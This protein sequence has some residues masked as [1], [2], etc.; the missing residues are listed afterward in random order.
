MKGSVRSPRF[1]K[2]GISYNTVPCVSFLPWKNSE[3][4]VASASA[5][6]KS[7]GLSS[8][9]GS[10]DARLRQFKCF[11]EYLFARF[12]RTYSTKIPHQG[13]PRWQPFASSHIKLLYYNRK[14]L[15]M[16]Y[17]L[18]LQNVDFQ[19]FFLLTF[20]HYAQFYKKNRR[21]PDRFEGFLLLSLI[22][23][24][25]CVRFLH[26]LTICSQFGIII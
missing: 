18:H 13:V 21:N 7:G 25:F 14:A 23:L 2:V 5:R 3:F 24:Y 15:K 11:G 22:F 26:L 17:F 8:H 19:P 10:Y 12:K 1:G 4:T 20:Y 16:Q 6:A 9:A